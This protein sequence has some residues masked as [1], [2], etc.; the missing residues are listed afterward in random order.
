MR[1]LII[2][3]LEGTVNSEEQSELLNWLQNKANKQQFDQIKSEWENKR[4][5]NDVS[6]EYLMGWANVQSKLLHEVESK[7]NRQL[8]F[9]LFFRYAAIFIALLAI[10]LLWHQLQKDD[11]EALTSFT[12]VSA[13]S[14][15]VTKV[16][17][18]DGSEVWLNYGSSIKYDDLFSKENRNIE[19]EGEAFFKAAKNKELPMVVSC[20]ELRVK[21]LGTSFNV[22]SYLEGVNIQVTLEEGVVLL[23]DDSNPSEVKKMKPGE[24][25][26]YSKSNKQISID[27]VNTDLFT[28][29]KDGVI[30]IYNL[31]LEELVLKLERRYN[32]KFEID[33]AAKSLRY[34]LTIKNET[35]HQV[36]DLLK[37]I[38]SVDPVQKN[39]IIYLKY[40]PQRA[41]EMNQD[42]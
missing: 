19:L 28:S 40:N 6:S 11:S 34:T 10:P 9:N 14:G 16:F 4:L 17:L 1:T 8:R 27:S 42:K 32:Q 22:M 25:G 30:N 13:D 20:A 15:Q 24:M 41:K 26:T 18:P 3:Y 39:D 38:N 2:K 12:K 31:T 29:W 23:Y 37:I 21:V 33:E 36:L 5:G 35:L 7:Q